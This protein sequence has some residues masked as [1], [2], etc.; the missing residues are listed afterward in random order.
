[1]HVNHCLGVPTAQA[2]CLTRKSDIYA[3][4]DMD[5]PSDHL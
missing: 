2:P 4:G 3:S 1:M 5:N